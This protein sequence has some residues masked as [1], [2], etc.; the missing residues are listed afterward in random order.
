M[1]SFLNG[2]ADKATSTRKQRYFFLSLSPPLSHSHAHNRGSSA[3]QARTSEF[4]PTGGHA[5]YLPPPP[6]RAVGRSRI[7]CGS[8]GLRTLGKPGHAAFS[9]NVIAVAHNY[10]DIIAYHEFYILARRFLRGERGRAPYCR[11]GMLF[12]FSCFVF[13]CQA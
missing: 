12:L 1:I 10:R 3:L 13:G 7:P 9:A 6:P 2:G 8:L 11:G 4:P 5:T